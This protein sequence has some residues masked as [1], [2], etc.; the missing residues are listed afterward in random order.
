[1]KAGSV[2]FAALL[3][4]GT[5]SAMADDPPRFK[6]FGGLSYVAPIGE[7][8]ITVDNIE[9]N[10][11]E[12]NEVGWTV[13]LEFRFNQILGLEMDY[14][15]ATNDVEFGG[16]VVGDV[17]MQPLSATL[18]F[19]LIPTKVVDLYIG[20]TASYFIWGDVDLGSTSGEFKTDNDVAWGASLG[21]EIGIGKTFA[22][23]GGLR[24]LNADIEPEGLDKIGVD[25]LFGRLGVALRF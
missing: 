2:V 9:D 14:V 10:V 21:L 17:H 15:N 1:M 5:T 4:L 20:P 11:E 6:I 13:G 3:V 24:W 12:S 18:N 22:L 16:Q 7:D 19:H 8:E 23:M 25:P